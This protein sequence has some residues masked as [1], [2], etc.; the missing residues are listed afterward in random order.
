VSDEG[1]GIPRSAIPTI[2]LYSY[3]TAKPPP[4]DEDDER[5][6]GGGGG[7]SI[8]VPLAGYG[9]GLPMSRLV[10]LKKKK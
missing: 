8:R 6:G 3:S 1:G 5:G 9:Y 10:C 4:G 2:W 7:G